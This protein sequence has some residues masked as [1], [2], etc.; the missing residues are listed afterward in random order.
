M[1]ASHPRRAHSLASS[2]HLLSPLR[3]ARVQRAGGVGSGRAGW[4]WGR[5][6]STGEDAL[7]ARR[8][9]AQ[10]KG[11]AVRPSLRA[12][13]AW[14][15]LHHPFYSPGAGGAPVLLRVPSPGLT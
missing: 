4:R 3:A 5:R 10:A 6:V 15:A 14:S 1:K 9:A 13:V 2:A 11:C 12:T 7:P 8:R